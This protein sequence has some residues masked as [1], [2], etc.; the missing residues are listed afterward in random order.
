MLKVAFKFS[1][2]R[3]ILLDSRK[4]FVKYL[5]ISLLF[6][7]L[8]SAVYKINFIFEGINV[9]I[10]LFWRF[11]G[12]KVNE[13]VHVIDFSACNKCRKCEQNCPAKAINIDGQGNVVE[14]K[15]AP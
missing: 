8:T 12:Y 11:G 9:V 2:A 3:I 15:L 6:S 4:L 13:G 1:G 14:L 5:N 7:K 10:N